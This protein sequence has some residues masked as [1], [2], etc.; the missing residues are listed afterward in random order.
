MRKWGKSRNIIALWFL[1]NVRNLQ[2][3]ST[4]R[5]KIILCIWE[6]WRRLCLFRW[7]MEYIANYIFLL[8]L[9]NKMLSLE[10]TNANMIDEV[11]KT[12]VIHS[13]NSSKRRIGNYCCSSQKIYHPLCHLQKSIAFCLGW[14]RCTNEEFNQCFPR[15][16]S[17]YFTTLLI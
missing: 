3:V 17:V 12:Q 1:P 7:F 2:E 9:R 10:K 15:S 11:D 4:S 6:F 8:A 14:C 16:S 13:V 5:T